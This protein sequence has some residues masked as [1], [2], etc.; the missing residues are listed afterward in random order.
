MK[1]SQN[2]T[3][4]QDGDNLS[5]EQ[6]PSFTNKISNYSHNCYDTHQYCLRSFFTGCLL[7]IGINITIP[8]IV[9]VISLFISLIGISI[10]IVNTIFENVIM[11]LFEII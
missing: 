5:Q 8:I 3:T 9:V 2:Y 7:F 11:T 6:H 1:L 4:I 10:V